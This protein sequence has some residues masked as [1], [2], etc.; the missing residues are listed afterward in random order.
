M[1][2]TG[3]VRRIDDLGRVSIPKEIRRTMHLHDGDPVELFLSEDKTLCLRRY[4]P[5]CEVIKDEAKFLL[6]AFKDA[7][8][9]DIIVVDDI[10]CV[11]ESTERIFIGKRLDN[12]IP[13]DVSKATSVGFSEENVV[14]SGCY[15]IVTDKTQFSEHYEGAVLII[16]ETVSGPHIA[17][18]IAHAISQKIEEHF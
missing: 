6:P 18:A 1:K 13:V 4:Q 11:I 17:Q 12:P 15:R 10:G 14:V 16:G 8:G 2:S 7:F 3:I 9:V 5:L